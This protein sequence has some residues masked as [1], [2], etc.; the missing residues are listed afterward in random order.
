M[1]ALVLGALGASR[2]EIVAEYNRSSAKVGS[3]PERLEGVLDEIDAL[4][5]I[6]AF[7]ERAG[8][9]SDQLETLRE[10]ATDTGE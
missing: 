1:S 9:R 8:V 4:G 7:L 5:G 3:T 10:I 6:E 2:A